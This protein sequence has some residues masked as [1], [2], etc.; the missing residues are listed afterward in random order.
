L[1]EDHDITVDPLK[2]IARSLRRHCELIHNYLRAQKL[3]STDA[4]ERANDKAT[5]RRSYRV[6][7]FRT[8]EL[9][10]YHSFG[11]LP[12]PESTHEFF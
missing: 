10:L 5:M 8:L 4:I 12:E 2:K 9:T 6:R 7:I 11:K 3:L 1:P